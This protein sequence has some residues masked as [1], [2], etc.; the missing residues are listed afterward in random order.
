[1]YATVAEFKAWLTD[2]VGYVENADGGSIDTLLE[3]CLSSATGDIE[4]DTGRVFAL[5]TPAEARSF[6]VDIDGLVHVTDLVTVT[7][8]VVDT[9][10]DD[11]VDKTLASTD[12]ML[13]PKTDNRG[14]AGVRYQLIKATP[15]GGAY[16]IPGYRVTVTSTWGYVESSAAPKQIKTACLLRAARTLA[17]RD[18]RLGSLIMSMGSSSVEVVAKL[19][20]DY[21]NLIDAYRVEYYGVS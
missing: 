20:V 10:G 9:N 5:T 21:E 4:D 1:M 14:R 2:K 12:Y 13:L 11:V 16:F 18:A 19:D 6:Y 3:D 7:S 15:S 17:R 8:V